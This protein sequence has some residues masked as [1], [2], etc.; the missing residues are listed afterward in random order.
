MIVKPK[1]MTCI[2]NVEFLVK[3][4]QKSVQEEAN[5][6][7]K[8]RHPSRIYPFHLQVIGGSNIRITS[9]NVCY[10][11]LLRPSLVLSNLKGLM[12]LPSKVVQYPVLVVK[13][14]STVAISVPSF[15]FFTLFA[16]SPF[17]VA[18]SLW[19]A[20]IDPCSKGG[21]PYSS[22]R[23][24][25]NSNIASCNDRVTTFDKWCRF[26][27]EVEIW[28]YRIIFSP[29]VDTP[30]VPCTGES[31]SH[32]LPASRRAGFAKNWRNNFV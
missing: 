6:P 16:L 12:S 30:Q 8:F 5:T 14:M 9:Y 2:W 21:Y 26:Q 29:Q 25:I 22:V 32:N 1:M 10:T 3:T 27:S 31:K 19:V 7:Q 28:I 18:S 24:I 17:I 23:S 20:G 4:P 15:T 13:P 11:K